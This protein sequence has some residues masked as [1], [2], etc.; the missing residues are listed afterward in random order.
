M[1]HLKFIKQ[2]LSKCESLRPDVVAFA[3]QTPNWVEVCVSDHDLYFY[4]KRFQAL[5]KAW[6]KIANQK[7]FKLIFFYCYPKEKN[8]LELAENDNLIM[9]L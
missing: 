2:I 8:L 6:H 7:G 3:S 9:N 1:K 5:T 4:D